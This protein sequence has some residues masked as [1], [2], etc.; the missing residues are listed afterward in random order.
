MEFTSVFLIYFISL[1]VA[2]P[3]IDNAD[4]EQAGRISDVISSKIADYT[5]PKLQLFQEQ[6]YTIDEVLD[7]LQ[8]EIETQG[9]Q[10]T[11]SKIRGNV[12]IS[13]YYY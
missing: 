7:V 11:S 6:N 12:P 1:A 3:V 5:H 9:P 13:S 8:Q 10:Q 2:A 4:G